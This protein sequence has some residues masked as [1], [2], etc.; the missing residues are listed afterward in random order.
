MKYENMP[1]M[2]CRHILWSVAR[3]G[4]SNRMMKGEL[5]ELGEEVDSSVDSISKVQTQILNLTSGKVNIFNDKGEFRDYYD[6]MQD[7]ANI[8][9][10]LTSTNQAA[11]TEILFGKMRGNQGS[12]LIKAFQTGRIEEAFQSIQES[13][14]SAM[15]EQERWM[16]S[17]EAKIAQFKATFQNLSTTVISSDL[18]KNVVDGGTEVL[19]FLNKLID[20]TGALIPLLTAIAGIETFKHFGNSNTNFALY[21]CES[22]VA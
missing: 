20:K 4:E 7:I 5:E 11:L 3:H 8:Y 10:N 17:I 13:A 21:G 18:V 6:I 2:T 14:G 16:E 9:D 22:I 1:E 12:A 19:N 15:K